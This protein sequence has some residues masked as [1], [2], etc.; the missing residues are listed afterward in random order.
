MA[1]PAAPYRRRA[2]KGPI[3]LNGHQYH[4]AFRGNLDGLSDEGVI[5]GWVIRREGGTGRVP[6]ALYAGDTL[7]DAGIADAVRE[8]AATPAPGS[9]PRAVDH[10]EAGL[11]LWATRGE[12]CPSSP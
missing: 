12:P 1:A 3:D 8:A 6:V 7:L 4:G 2:L 10:S 11:Y 9:R 5:R